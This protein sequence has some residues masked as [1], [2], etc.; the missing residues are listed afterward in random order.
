L[1]KLRAEIGGKDHEIAIQRVDENVSALIDGR[2]YDLRVKDVGDGEYLLSQGHSVFNCRAETV[3][4]QPND[5]EV[6]VQGNSY[7]IK[8][9]DPKRLR[10]SQTGADHDRGSAQIVAPMPGKVVRVL[11]EVGAQV[12]AGAG[13]VVVEAM[14]M[15]NEMKSPKAGTVIELKT[16]AGSTVNAGDVLAVVE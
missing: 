2:H 6:T 9:I 4:H 7:Q 14:K 1:I 13:L 16:T 11:V 12:G 5:L 10:S 15:Q 3:H 8:L